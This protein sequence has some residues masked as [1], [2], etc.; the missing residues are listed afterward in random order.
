[1]EDSL[2]FNVL[3][4]VNSKGSEIMKERLVS[5]DLESFNLGK[6]EEFNFDDMKLI[7]R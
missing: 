7:I 5:F 3:D 1:M 6:E 4:I 2:F